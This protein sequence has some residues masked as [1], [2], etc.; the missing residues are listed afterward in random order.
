MLPD[1]PFN[2]NH[3]FPAGLIV[4][5]RHLEHFMVVAFLGVVAFVAAS[6]NLSDA[7]RHLENTRLLQ[8]VHLGR[9]RYLLPLSPLSR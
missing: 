1:Q 4:V 7:L 5:A 2:Q 8:G 6:H 3:P 9:G